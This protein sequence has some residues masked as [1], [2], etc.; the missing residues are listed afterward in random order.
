[1][2]CNATIT[3]YKSLRANENG[4]YPIMF[5]RTGDTE[6]KPTNLPC[7]R[8]MGCRIAKSKEWTIRCL[9][10]SALHDKNCFVTLTYDDNNLPDN[11]SLVKSDL[12]KFFKRL[13]KDYNVRFFACG[14]YGD[15]LDRPHYH[16]LIFGYD[17]SDDRD[18][19]ADGKYRLYRSDYLERKWPCGYSTIGDL[20]PETA[21]YTARYCVKKVTGDHAASHYV[22]LDESTGELYYV[23]P[24][25]IQMSRRP[26]IGKAWFDQFKTDCYPKDF[27]TQ[28]G[29]RYKIPKYYDKL[30][31]DIAPLELSQVKEARKVKAL[32]IPYDPKRDAQRDM[33]VRLKINSQFKERN[34]H[35]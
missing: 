11:R 10:E 16:A 26:G 30:L 20:T 22:R 13:R 17:F 4:K 18:L 23:E 8:C 5:R 14:E 15:Q 34:L 21:A 1:M 9:H 35:K 32:D 6:F 19:V 3:G 24:E 25:F 27:I 31:E 7:G 12:Q 2:G 33:A 28:A 29:K